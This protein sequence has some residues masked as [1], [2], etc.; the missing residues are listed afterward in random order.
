M[1][2]SSTIAGL[3]QSCSHHNLQPTIM[4][5]P[6]QP[7]LASRHAS[8][9]SLEMRPEQRTHRNPQGSSSCS[10][11]GNFQSVNLLGLPWPPCLFQSIIDIY[12]SQIA[13]CDEIRDFL[14]TNSCL[15]NSE[16]NDQWQTQGDILTIAMLPLVQYEQLIF[17]SSCVTISWHSLEDWHELSCCSSPEGRKW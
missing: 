3:P 11:G 9:K 8:E 1:R 5:S 6:S 2:L 7:Q 13:F 10:P 12:G 4:E 15:I 14:L 17:G 16:V